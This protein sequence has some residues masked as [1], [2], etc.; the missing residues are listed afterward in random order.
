MFL[1]GSSSDKQNKKEDK[2]NLHQKNGSTLTEKDFEAQSMLSI[3]ARQFMEHRL[4]VVGLVVIAI[5]VG[6]AAFAPLI[7][8]LT[9]IDPEAQNVFNRYK[10]AMTT[11]KMS[12]DQQEVEIEK[13]I[14]SDPARAA[15]IVTALKSQGIVGQN[16]TEE[17]A[18][19]DLILEG[20]E[21]QLAAFAKSKADAI[22]PLQDLVSGFQT[23]HLFGTDELGRDVF[24]RLVYGTRVSIFVGILVAIAA[25]FIGLII[26]SLAGYYGGW[27]DT[28]LS[29][30]IDSLLSLPLIPML[31][32]FA[33]VDLKKV[34]IFGGI[35]GGEN[36]SIIKLVAILVLFSWMTVARL[37][38]G[39]I[40]AIKNRE[41]IL[42]AK[43]LGAK[44]WL[45]IGTHI[46]P[47]VVAPLLVAVTLNVG[48]SILSEAALS[49]LGLGIQPPT[50][51]WGNMLFNAQEL[52]F[53]APL[54]AILPG[55]LI[56]ATVISFNFVGDG[57]QDAIDP[58]AI[59]R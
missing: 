48:N 20:S 52:I 54:L 12:T 50:P 40:L 30:I 18:I 46:V 19:Y 15:E 44:D 34:P 5:F 9:G 22:A 11:I 14:E 32:V 17:D 42:A 16:A 24:M 23:F 33:A 59:K 43:T 13:F 53:E 4:A 8:S 31:I 51:S 41:F 29:R 56:L 6:I 21:E 27:V 49:F 7:S 3:V 10:P 25:A 37:V 1:T 39:S 35:A 57:L 45:V 58:K 47:N 36:E 28:V 55:L 26:G 38:R 2:D